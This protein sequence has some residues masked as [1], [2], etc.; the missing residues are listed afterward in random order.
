MSDLNAVKRRVA[1][2]NRIL[3]REG[4]VDAFG[5][6][7]LRH[8]DEPGQYLLSCSRSPELV[9]PGDVMA[10]TLDGDDAETS[11][12]KPYL[13][14]H[15]HGAVFEARPDINAVV[16]NHAYEVVPFSLTGLGM[17][18]VLHTAAVIGA[19]VPVWDI[20][21]N[22]GD[23]DLLVRNMDQGRDL[24][25]AL[26]S[27]TAILMRG[28]G[29]TVA[30]ASLEEAVVASVYLMVNARIVA[31]AAGLSESGLAGVRHLSAA[32]VESCRATQLGD[33]SLGRVWEYLQA[34]AGID[35]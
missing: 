12:G 9:A 13:E 27:R 25:A 35:F 5:H 23:T 21:E 24:A 33:V 17:R 20:A 22:F 15:I 1:V 34:R 30:G 32:E 4:V 28:H 16:H 31:E 11:T 19:E 6:V 3:A 10:F 26:G 29:A 7:S 18:P 2:A 8:P 14:R